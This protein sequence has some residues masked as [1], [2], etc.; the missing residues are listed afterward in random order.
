LIF[1]LALFI[2]F[3]VS[4]TGSHCVVQHDLKLLGLSK[5]PVSSSL[6]AGTTGV[7]YRIHLADKRQMDK[8]KGIPIL[9]IL[10]VHRSSKKSGAQGGREMWGRTKC[11]FQHPETDELCK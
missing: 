9:L 5:P 4:G 7:W 8:R 11:R 1:A 6:A 10:Y 2:L 3:L